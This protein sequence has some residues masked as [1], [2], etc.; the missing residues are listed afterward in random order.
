M[1]ITFNG[2]PDNLQ[3]N[4]VTCIS[5]TYIHT[6]YTAGTPNIIELAILIFRYIYSL[7][8]MHDKNYIL[9]YYKNIIHGNIDFNKIYDP[10]KVRLT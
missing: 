3:Y 1:N 2:S 4:I 5:D 6:T 10:G 9:L 8:E 7:Y